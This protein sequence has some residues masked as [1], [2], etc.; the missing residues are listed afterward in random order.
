MR[1]TFLS[2]LALLLLPSAFNVLLEKSVVHYFDPSHQKMASECTVSFFVFTFGVW[3]R[4]M[5]CL[6][7]S[8]VVAIQKQR[9]AERGKR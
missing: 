9:K 5:L 4:R 2:F 1:G 7:F 3:L 8:H 6:L